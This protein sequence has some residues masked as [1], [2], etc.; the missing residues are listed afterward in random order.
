[1]KVYRKNKITIGLLFVATLVLNLFLFPT[2][3]NAAEVEDPYI[4][5]TDATFAPFE[6]ENEDG[7]FVGIDIDI[8]TAIAEDQGFEFELRPM[9]FSAG[10]QAL[11]SNQVDGMIAAM[12]ITPERKEAFDFSDPYFEAGP[13]VAVRE[14]NEDINSYADLEG[15]T[16]A[17]K[18]GT[19]GAQ[20]ANEIAED[21]SIEINQF[22]DS[23]SM[24]EDVTAQ[25]SDAVIEDYPVMAYAIQQGLELRFP[26]EAEEGDSYGFAV[27]KGMHPELIEMFNAGLANIREDGTHEEITNRYLG[28]SAEPQADS[29]F[30]GLIAQN[31]GDL[32]RGLGRTLV[33]TL[34]SFAISLIAGT[35]FGLFSAAPS[36][37]LNLIA[38]IY[39]TVLR[40]I[41]LIVLAFFMYFS[42]PQLLGIQITAFTAGIITLSLNTTAYI[43]EQVRGGI[44]A[45]DKGQLEAARS[46]GL[47]YGLSMRK[48]VV[49]QA[50]KIMIPSLINQFVITLKDT[51]ILAVIGIVELTQTG[52]IIIARSYE[53]GAMW[54]IVGLIYLIIITLLTKLSNILERRLIAND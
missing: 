10:L 21:Y 28:E 23:A 41:P 43:A 35:I 31:A 38:N 19:T 27:N 32:M 4:I 12:S 7:E 16:V 48:V 11:E 17:V 50:I 49:P 46:L 34:I 2:D 6:F 47:P 8:L 51:S 22:E 9:N 37:A 54:I 33:L 1:M 5:A 53:S 24:Y 13:V 18:V 25:H 52:R 30:F 20:L 44:A 29:G 3:T 36:K 26:T 39:V 42:V 15:K 45:V 14:D 40:G